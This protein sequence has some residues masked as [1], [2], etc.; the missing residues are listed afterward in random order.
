MSKPKWRCPACRSTNPADVVACRVCGFVFVEANAASASPRPVPESAP[1]EAQPADDGASAQHSKA[2]E[3]IHT[4]A[5]R[6]RPAAPASRQAARHLNGH[7]RGMISFAALLGL[8]ALA[9]IAL[10][11]FAVFRSI[12][13]DEGTAVRSLRSTKD[14]TMGAAAALDGSLSPAFTDTLP[15]TETPLPLPTSTETPLPSP[16]PTETPLPPPTETPIPSPTP[17]EVASPSPT[18]SEVASPSPTETPLPNAAPAR[19]KTYTVQQGDTCWAIATRFGISVEQLVAQN[20]LSPQCVIRPG[21][22]LTIAR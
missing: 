2:T 15:P 7:R 19:A 6:A 11:A 16:T 9:A 21:Q 8:A 3:A 13:A 18:P 5:P 10:L 14:A 4:P 22:V 12:A 17:T 1:D 20:R